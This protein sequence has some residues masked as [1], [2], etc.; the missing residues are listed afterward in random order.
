MFKINPL[1][2]PLRWKKSALI[3][4]LVLFFVLWFGFF[5]S[6]SIWT[7]YQLERE[8]KDLI[9]RTEQLVADT[10]NLRLKIEALRN[11]PSLLEKIAREEYGMRRPGETVYRIRKND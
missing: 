10:Q 1:L 5:D 2:N 3:S 8:K 4:M 6:Y 9:H 7:R 11:D